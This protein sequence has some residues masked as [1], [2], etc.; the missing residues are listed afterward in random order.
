MPETSSA[1]RL[2][3]ACWT[4][5]GNVRPGITSDVSPVPF[6]RR[7][8]AVKEAGYVGIGF[9]LADLDH[10]RRTI[11]LDGLHD[12]IVES[13]LEI[14]Q[15]EFLYDWWVDGERRRA[16]DE[17]RARLFE[18]AEVLGADNVK[19]GGGRPGDVRDPEQLRESFREL[20][21]QAAAHHTR[22]ALEPGAFSGLGDFAATIAMVTDVAHPHGGMLLD[23]WH[24]YRAGYSYD[25]LVPL[26]PL[27]HL[28]AVELDDGAAEPVG[29]I[30]D[31][32]FDNRLVCGRGAFDVPAF[33]RAIRRTGFDGPWG[34]EVMSSS[35]R[36]LPVEQALKEARDG[37][38]DCLRRAAD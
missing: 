16:S 37:A 6:E 22:I 28:V 8:R 3:A 10:A 21:D 11:G 4:S 13:G 33:I 7:V 17:R 38:L 26:L 34:V 15:V 25:A 5:A 29:T 20:S 12:L 27:D 19:L 32:T 14:V 1:P 9:E 36:A 2:I 18:A 35:L 30:F 23:P 31:D 24:L